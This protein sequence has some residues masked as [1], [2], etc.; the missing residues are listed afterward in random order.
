[1]KFA[2][3]TPRYGAEIGSGPERACRLIAEHLTGLHDVDVVTT[4]ASNPETWRNECPAGIDRVRGVLVRR[5]AAGPHDRLYFS[6]ISSRMLGRTHSRADEREWVHLRGPSSVGLVEYLKRSHRSY[7]AVVFFSLSHATTLDGMAAVPDRSVLFPWLHLEPALR[8]GLW[9]DLFGAARGVGYISSSEQHLAHSYLRVSAAAEEVV[10][11]GVDVPSQQTYPRHQQ[12]PADEATEDDDPPP[13]GSGDG[14]AADYLTQ[15]GTLFRRRHRLYGPFVLYGGRVEPDNGAEEML[16]Y[17]HSYAAEN[18]ATSLVLMGVKLFKVPEAPYVRLAGVLPEGERMAANEAADVT[19]APDPED[20]AASAVLESFAVG[21]PV[22]A[23]ATNPAA[24]DHCRRS[25]AGLYYAN[26]R[27]FVEALRLLLSDAQLRERL[28]DNG[29][30]Y[31]RQHFR[32]DAVLGR[33]ERLVSH[34][35]RP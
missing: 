4:C 15:R 23:A 35:R 19:L 26:R 18:G 29:R 25:N 10:G 21:T 11:L 5:F 34:V 2:F 20:L 32:W 33:F 13:A 1:L 6:E 9:R 22:L 14:A 27:E 7:D 31:M 24:V 8:F 30:R 16:E 17:F 3:V 12:D 28:G